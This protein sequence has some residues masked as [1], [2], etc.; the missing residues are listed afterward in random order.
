MY[1]FDVH[2]NAYFPL[3][4]LLYGERLA[5]ALSLVATHDTQR[6]M[7]STRVQLKAR[8]LSCHEF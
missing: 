5:L 2:C 8:P 6:I 7:L 1:A 4:I 3:F